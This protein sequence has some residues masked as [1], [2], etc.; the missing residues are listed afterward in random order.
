MTQVR[1]VGVNNRSGLLS[2]M[3]RPIDAI[4]LTLAAI[5]LLV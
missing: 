4:L 3:L 5:D 1:V 2:S